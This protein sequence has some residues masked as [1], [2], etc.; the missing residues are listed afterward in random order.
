MENL[1]I[2]VLASFIALLITL[3]I[4][5]AV[6]QVAKNDR[7]QSAQLKLLAEIAAKSGVDIKRIQVILRVADDRSHFL[8]DQ[9]TSNKKQDSPLESKQV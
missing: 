8:P 1:A 5:K 4:A 6:F 9:N 3:Y 2:Y 7:I